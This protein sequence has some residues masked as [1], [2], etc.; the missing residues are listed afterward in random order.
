MSTSQHLLIIFR[1]TKL[2]FEGRW[3]VS[4]I[5]FTSFISK[6]L[7]EISLLVIHPNINFTFFAQIKDKIFNFNLTLKK[8]FVIKNIDIFNVY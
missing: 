1:G 5:S 4:G 8:Y 3:S 2:L 6:S 7:L